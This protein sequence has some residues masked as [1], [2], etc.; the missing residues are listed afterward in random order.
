MFD[1]S[2]S[3]RILYNLNK[4]NAF[5]IISMVYKIHAQ[6]TYSEIGHIDLI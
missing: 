2:I 4:M 3:K 1:D 6:Y 5:R